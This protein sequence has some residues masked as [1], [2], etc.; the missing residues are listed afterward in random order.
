MTLYEEAQQGYKAKELLENEIYKAA[1]ENIRAGIVDKWRACP[2]RDRD[3]AHELKLLDK[4]L[5]ELEGYIKQVADSGKMA[6]IQLE[7]E[8]KIARLKQSGIR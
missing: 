6:E 2:I 3:G 8:Q 4:L 1:I 5:G 7:N